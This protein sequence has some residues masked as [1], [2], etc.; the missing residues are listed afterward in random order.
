MKWPSH[1]LWDC[2]ICL[3]ALWKSKHKFPNN[4]PLDPG[5]NTE[6]LQSVAGV[7]HSIL[8]PVW[9]AYTHTHTHTYIYNKKDV[10]II[11]CAQLSANIDSMKKKLFRSLRWRCNRLRY[12]SLDKRV[13]LLLQCLCYRENGYTI[14]FVSWLRQKSAEWEV[15]PLNI[16]LSHWVHLIESTN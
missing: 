1:N 15:L 12:E 7:N 9:F 4:R 5:L 6:S 10:E 13:L 14:E 8:R 2:D 3:E 11:Q 16:V